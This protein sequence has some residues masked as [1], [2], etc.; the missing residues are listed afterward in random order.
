MTIILHSIRGRV[1]DVYP[2]F[3]IVEAA[4]G[5]EEVNIG[6]EENKTGIVEVRIGIVDVKTSGADNRIVVVEVGNGMA[7][8]IL[9]SGK[10][11]RH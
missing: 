7:E 1:D 5:M 4:K 2:V 9:K 6:M 3:H 10:I 11:L 8:A